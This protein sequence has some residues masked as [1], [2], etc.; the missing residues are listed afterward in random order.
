MTGCDTMPCDVAW[1]DVIED[2][3]CGV[4]WDDVS[5]LAYAVVP[6]D[7]GCGEWH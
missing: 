5:L 3:A 6:L 1:C 2:D 7:P 4:V